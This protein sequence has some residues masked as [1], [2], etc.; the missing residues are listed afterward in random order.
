MLTP[1]TL[2]QGRYR[3]VRQ[4]GQGGMG[5]VYEAV[6]TRLHSKVAI[7][8]LLGGNE[9]IRKAFESEAQLLAHL[10]H[11]ALP[12]V[13][14]YFSEDNHLFLVMEYIEGDDLATMLE[15]RHS[16]FPVERV[17]F[18]ADKLLDTLNYLHAQNPPIIHRDIKPQNIKLTPSGRLYLLDFGLA[19]SAKGTLVGGYTLHYAPFE[20]I[21]GRS[22]DARGDIYSLGA[23]LHHL[24]TNITPQGTTT[25]ASALMSQLPD[26][27]LAAHDL[28]PQVPKA[29]SDVLETAMDM[30]PDR[31]YQHAV[32]MRAALRNALQEETPAP[33]IPKKTVLLNGDSSQAISPAQS[34][35]ARKSSSPAA[36]IAVLLLL[37][38]CGSAGGAA[39]AFGLFG[40]NGIFPNPLAGIPATATLATN[41]PTSSVAQTEPAGVP[42]EP[43]ATS[44]RVPPTPTELPAAVDT[45]IWR[46]PTTTV[47]SVAFSY[48]GRLLASTDETT[49]KLWDAGS[50]TLVR[51]L[52]GHASTVWGIAFAPSGAL[53]ASA[54]DDNMVKLWDAGTGQLLRTL[55]GHTQQVYSVVFSPD[56]TILASSSSDASVRVWNVDDGSQLQLLGHPD[57]VYSAAFSPD[58]TLL[59]SVSRD[60]KVRLWNVSDGTLLRTLEGHTR[61]VHTVAFAPDGQSFASGAEDGTIRLWHVPDGEGLGILQSSTSPGFANMVNSLDFSPNGKLLLSGLNDNTIQLWD[62]A[63][64]RL[65][66]T[67]RGHT[68][69]VLS[70]AFAPNGTTFAS[71]G[72]D[73]TLRLWTLIE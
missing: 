13:T 49:V 46:V 53:L 22:T 14:D 20:Q 15:R 6:D 2:L 29:V 68:Q 40:G 19:R 45:I 48:D 59:A 58:G 44:T 5:S 31:R 66:H 7:K 8:Q 56:G 24:L 37:L 65:L 21:Q 4:I 9:Q 35:P 36:I 61:A 50:R 52:Q 54:S 47:T 41:Q 64:K 55:E 1:D 71:G 33:V 67:L 73:G 32:L 18:W 51:S 62:V 30:D 27:Q 72:R 17:L 43:A 42:T 12:R 38:L 26:P 25:R 3:I 10:Q 16:P 63:E 57:Q 70:V 11:E 60:K 28:N 34:T 69:R 23:T 39:W